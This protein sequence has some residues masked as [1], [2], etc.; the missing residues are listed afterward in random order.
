MASRIRISKL[1]EL[2]DSKYESTDVTIEAGAKLRGV[3]VTAKKMVIKRNAELTDCKLFSDGTITIG[4]NTV[5][6]ERSII[7]AFNSIFIGDRT[8]IDRDVFIGGMP[9]E[10]SQLEVGSDCVILYRSYLNTTCKISIG[11]NVGIGGY[12]LIFTHSAWQNAL[13]GGHYKFANV[14]VKDNVWVTWNVTILPGV[15]IDRNVIVGS[16]SVVTKSLPASV[17]A[18]G[19]PAKI[20]HRRDVQSL[21]HT[22]KNTI[23]IEILH[24][25]HQYASHYL[26]LKNNIHS[27]SNRVTIE[28]NKGRLVYTSEFK[29]INQGNDIL[30]YFKIPDNL[31][32]KY[33]WIELDSLKYHTN[34]EIARLFIAFVRRYGLKIRPQDF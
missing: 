28:F 16:G 10:K 30:I 25:F 13:E 15:T 14:D 6:K 3:F 17:F 18:A 32:Q 21:S 23:M 7:N 22:S 2:Q 27:Y 5:I 8:L 29:K 31:K 20:I 33:D 11:N 26:K 24:D 4:E 1:A 12:C 34:K 9:S 19:A